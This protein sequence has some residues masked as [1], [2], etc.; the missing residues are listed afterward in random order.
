MRDSL[1]V[2]PQNLIR[3]IGK[4][5]AASAAVRAHEVYSRCGDTSAKPDEQHGIYSPKSQSRWRTSA[6]FGRWERPR[7]LR[8]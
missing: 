1:A 6:E 2:P 7:F 4:S 8:G 5:H 3:L